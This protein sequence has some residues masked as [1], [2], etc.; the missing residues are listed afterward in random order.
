MREDA[1]HSALPFSQVRNRSSHNDNSH[2]RMLHMV[3]SIFGC[4]SAGVPELQAG[5]LLFQSLSK[6]ES[7]VANALRDPEQSGEAAAGLISLCRVC[8]VSGNG[9]GGFRNFHIA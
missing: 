6:G 9:G 7:T 3:C 5:S 4:G 8:F 2:Q 1:R